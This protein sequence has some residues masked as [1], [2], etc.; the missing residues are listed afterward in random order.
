MSRISRLSITICPIKMPLFKMRCLIPESYNALK[1]C[2]E[3]IVTIDDYSQFNYV[4]TSTNAQ[5]Y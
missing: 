4:F 5:V 3:V 2:L 1:I